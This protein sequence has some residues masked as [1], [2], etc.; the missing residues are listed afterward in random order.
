MKTELLKLEP[1]AWFEARSSRPIP[2]KTSFC[3]PNPCNLWINSDCLQPIQEQMIHLFKL[4]KPRKLPQ[5]T[6]PEVL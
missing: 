3:K 5:K 1:L 4:L 6:L 2:T